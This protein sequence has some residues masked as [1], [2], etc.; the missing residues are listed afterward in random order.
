MN[1]E[2]RF[3]DKFGIASTHFGGL[4][5]AGTASGVSI[6]G[7][8]ITKGGWMSI[9]FPWVTIILMFVIYYFGLQVARMKNFEKYN[10][11]LSF[12]YG[13]FKKYFTLLGELAVIYNLMF[14]L[15]LAFSGGGVL[16]NQFIGTPVLF[17]VIIIS[18]VCI[19][20]SFYG[21][22]FLNKIQSIMTFGMLAILFLTYIPALI[23]G[24]PNLIEIVKSGWMPK[25][26][27]FGRGFYWAFADTASFASFLAIY[28]LNVKKFNNDKDLKSTLTLGALMCSTALWLPALVL[29]SYTEAVSQEIPTLYIMQN[30]ISF[31]GTTVAYALLLMLAFISTGASCLT[32]VSDRFSV[33]VP[34]SINNN[35]LK[36]LTVCIFVSVISIFIAQSGIRNVFNLFTP[37]GNILSLTLLAIPLL[38]ILPFKYFRCKKQKTL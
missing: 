37:I 27:N 14:S 26:A 1:E 20:I 17:G 16:L 36:I 9:F 19:F 34:K 28:M 13:D 10:E 32:A 23:K 38:F 12:A 21:L 25:G 3:R 2:L 5:G 24:F 8:F 18:V 11:V 30:V 7:F 15:A 4:L 6:A 33:F 35:N 29:L 31:K 22:D